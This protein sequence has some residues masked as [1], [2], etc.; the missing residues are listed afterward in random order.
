MISSLSCL[1]PHFSTPVGSKTPPNCL[2]LSPFLSNSDAIWSKLPL[3]AQAHL[4]AFF[5]WVLLLSFGSLSFHSLFCEDAET[6]KDHPDVPLQ[7]TTEPACRE[8]LIFH[9]V[10]GKTEAQRG[11]GHCYF[12]V[13]ASQ[14]AQGLRTS[15][16]L[17]RAVS[18][19]EEFN[20]DAIE[21]VLT[22]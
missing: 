6:W 22:T 21:S 20:S 11:Q 17:P 10:F 1:S 8:H 14:G 2:L 19:T 5:C 18:M 7:K 3:V 15:A 12:R 4:F 9:F 13:R 16:F